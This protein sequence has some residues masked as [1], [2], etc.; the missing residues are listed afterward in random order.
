MTKSNDRATRI[1]GDET[2]LQIL[3]DIQIKMERIRAILGVRKDSPFDFR[4]E[5]VEVRQ[6]SSIRGLRSQI[7]SLLRQADKP[8]TST[9][10]AEHL[11][12]ARMGLTRD[13]MRRKV[14]VAISALHKDKSS[15]KVVKVRTE[16][17]AALWALPG[18]DGGGVNE[19]TA[20]IESPTDAAQDNRAAV[21]LPSK[22]KS[23]ET[24]REPI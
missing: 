21:L 15:S 24:E 10:I 8:L 9:Q 17:P 23:E 22:M 3:D 2:I 18:W 16:G 7:L 12:D 20:P 13:A 5:R 14:N 6:T 19:V 1:E 11:Y 4:L